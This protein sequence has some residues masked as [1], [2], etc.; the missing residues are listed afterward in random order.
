MGKIGADFLYLFIG[1]LLLIAAF[2]DLIR[3]A[4]NKFEYK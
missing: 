4:T 1:G 2:I 3:I